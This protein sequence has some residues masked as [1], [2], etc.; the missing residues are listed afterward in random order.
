M[1]LN[2]NS[3][4]ILENERVILRPLVAEDY[5]LLLHFSLNEP[6]LWEY[7]LLAADG[8]ENLKSYLDFAFNE[9]STRTFLFILSNR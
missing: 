7:S 8:E 2:F 6:E 5:T 3:D 4:I 1:T 9:K